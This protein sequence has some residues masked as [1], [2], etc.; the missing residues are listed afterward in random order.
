MNESQSAVERNIGSYLLPRAFILALFGLAPTAVAVAVTLHQRRHSQ[1]L[2]RVNTHTQTTVPAALP[3][4]IV[5]VL[6][7]ILPI[8][9]FTQPLQQRGGLGLL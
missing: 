1:D 2:Q 8:V 9:V 6:A 3:A 4:D 5:V 7:L